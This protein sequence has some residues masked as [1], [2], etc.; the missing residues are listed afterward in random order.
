MDAQKIL[1]F[2][3]PATGEQFGQIPMTSN[4]EIEQGYQELREAYPIWRGMPVR[5]RVRILQ[6]FQQVLI[7]SLDEITDIL[8]RDCGKTRQDALIEVFITAD[9]MDQYRKHA[10]RWLRPKKVSRGLYLFKNC[11]VEYHPY[12][13]VGIIAPWNYPLALSIPPMISALLA[14]NTVMLKP[15]EVTG[16][17]SLL[18]A[19]LIKRVPELSPFVRVFHGDGSVGAAMVQMKPDYIFLTGSTPTGKI[20][21][22]AAAENLTPFACELGG[23]D[24]MLV[25]EDADI[26]SAAKWGVWGSNFNTGQTC[27]SVERVYVVESVY[28]EFVRYAVE[29]TQ[30]LK[31]GYSTELDSPLHLGPITDPRQLKTIQSHLEDALV[32]GARVAVGGKVNGMF[33][34]PTILLDVDHSMLVMQDETFGPLMPIMKVRDEAEAIRMAND[35]SFGLGASVWSRDVARAQRVAR[36]LEAAAIVVNDTIAQFGV[37]MLPFGGIKQSGYGRIHGKEGLMQFCQPYAFAVG[38]P[39]LA[40]DVATI[41]RSPGHYKSGAAIMKLAFGATPQQRL[42]PIT[43]QL[44]TVPQKINKRKFA[45]VLGLTGLLGAVAF[46]LYHLVGSSRDG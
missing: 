4:E 42:E 15:S 17:T 29:E 32:K 22:R 16:A 7:A 44:A 8:N 30:R 20:V 38:N 34:E 35:C 41:L 43:E 31:V 33:I 19:D 1:Y 6:R 46:G 11:H 24:A 2:T 14:G 13:V 39:P 37:P 10:E 3:N 28:D 26:A 9:M 23:K 40:I 25:L 36:Q 27:M 21:S 45:S 5:E 12:G 18:M